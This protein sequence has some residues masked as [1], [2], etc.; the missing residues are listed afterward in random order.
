[1]GAALSPLQLWK[2]L[3]NIGAEFRSEGAESE[4]I[5]ELPLEEVEDSEQPL[6]GVSGEVLGQKEQVVVS[7]TAGRGLE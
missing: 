6:E 2:Y 1:M 5:S 3:K 7:G 4:E